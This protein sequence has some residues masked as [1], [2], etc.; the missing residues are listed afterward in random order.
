MGFM[1]GFKAN[2]LGTKAYRT[3][4]NALQ[5]KQQGKYREC[6]EKLEE[7]YRLYGEAYK[8]GFRKSSALTSYGILSMQMGNFEQARELMLE[9]AKY[10]GVM[11]SAFEET[12][13]HKLCAYIYELANAFNRFYHETKIL[14]EEDAETK[15]SYIALLTLTKRI[16]ETCIEALGFQAP[17]RM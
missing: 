5:M 15:K 4:V 12:A 17:E 6:M 3:H 13:P 14:S 7:A 9:A 2:Q 11:E 16:L 1:D 8:M 10:N